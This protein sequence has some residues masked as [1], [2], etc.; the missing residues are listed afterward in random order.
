MSTCI[1]LVASSYQSPSVLWNG[2]FLSLYV[3]LYLF[4]LTFCDIFKQS[5]KRK[6]LLHV[7][8]LDLHD[9]STCWLQT[10]STLKDI[11]ILKS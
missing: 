2:L 1:I 9:I 6:F 3:L 10:S 7:I 11:V 8:G 4:A 5:E